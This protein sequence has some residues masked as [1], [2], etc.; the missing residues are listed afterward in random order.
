[1]ALSKTIKFIFLGNIFGS[2]LPSQSDQILQ[3]FENFQNLSKTAHTHKKEENKKLQ[4][5][6]NFAR[7]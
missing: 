6:S 1:L 7:I 3:S 4:I 2:D 5:S